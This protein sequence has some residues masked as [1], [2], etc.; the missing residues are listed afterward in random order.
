MTIVATAREELLKI[1]VTLNERQ[2]E[3]VLRFARRLT[4]PKKPSEWPGTRLLRLAGAFEGPPDV[5]E[6][7]DRYL[8]EGQ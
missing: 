2:A 7:H 8:A 6:Q 3:R 1:V 4:A 5:S